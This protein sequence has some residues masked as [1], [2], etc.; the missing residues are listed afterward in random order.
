M[1]QIGRK[2]LLD[3]S[4]E[5]PFEEPMVDVT[6]NV[7]ALISIAPLFISVEPALR[8]L[9]PLFVNDVHAC[10]GIGRKN[11]GVR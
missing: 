1:T 11:L 9:A 6:R 7:S 4:K 8:L 2:V 5:R 10:S 3:V